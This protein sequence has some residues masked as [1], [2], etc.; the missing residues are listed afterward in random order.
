MNNMAGLPPRDEPAALYTPWIGWAYVSLVVIF[1]VCASALSWPL[2][3]LAFRSDNSP[4]SWLSSAQLWAIGVIVARLLVEQA[5]PRLLGTVLLLAMVVM[6]FDEQFMLHELWKY[7]CDEWFDACR[8]AWVRDGPIVLVGVGG[9][10]AAAW[11]HQVIPPGW[12][13]GHLWSSIALGVFALTL[14]LCDP[15][16]AWSAYEEAFEVLAEAWFMACLLGLRGHN[17]VD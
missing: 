11:L 14:D 17:P 13:R 1:M 7:G 10:A 6:A 3:E 4:V 12:A 16:P 9:V 8:Y 15:V 2:P 5:I